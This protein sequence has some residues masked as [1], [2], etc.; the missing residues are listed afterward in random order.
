MILYL[1]IK[2]FD[3]LLFAVLSILPTFS[4]PAWFVTQLPEVLIR[5]ASFDNYLPIHETVGVV[6]G[7]ISLTFNYKIFKIILGFFHVD[8]NK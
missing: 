4:T 7:L 2:F 3:S 5:I 1:L 6:I 8:L